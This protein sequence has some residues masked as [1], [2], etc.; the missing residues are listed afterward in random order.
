[1]LKQAAQKYVPGTVSRTVTMACTPATLPIFI[2][3]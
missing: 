2:I 1:M 3:S